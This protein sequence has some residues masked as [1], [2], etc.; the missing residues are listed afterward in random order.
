[1]NRI[2]KMGLTIGAA[3]LVGVALY[4]W[5]QPP[6]PSY[7]GKSLSH[8]FAMVNTTNG[9]SIANT[10]PAVAAI[11]AMGNGALPFLV[12]KIKAGDSPIHH[13]AFDWLNRL[14]QDHIRSD[15]QRRDA[16]LQ[17]LLFIDE[18]KFERFTSHFPEIEN[19]EQAARFVL[20]ESSIT[21]Y[22]PGVLVGGDDFD[23]ALG[24]GLKVKNIL[25][26]SFFSSVYS[27]FGKEAIPSLIE[28]L[29]ND[30]EYVRYG[31]A[32]TLMTITGRYRS[33][34]DGFNRRKL[35]A[36][37][38]LWWFHNHDNPRLNQRPKQAFDAKHWDTQTPG[39]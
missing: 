23:I 30:A 36:D 8:W 27:Q 18:R 35:L 11:T 24:S 29:D 34:F 38:R 4:G 7:Q 16:A 20:N 3:A 31:A 6:E 17:C 14:S 1:M 12:A 13:R 10:D 21:N 19:P 26:E 9:V 37:W 5:L 25:V 2:Q 22:S 33:H 39:H 15:D 32:R 28:M